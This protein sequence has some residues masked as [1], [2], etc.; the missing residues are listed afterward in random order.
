MKTI[1]KFELEIKN[2]QIIEMPKNALILQTAQIQNGRPVIWAVCD[3]EEKEKSNVIILTLGTG[4][5]INVNIQLRFV[6]IG[7]YQLGS[8]V[9]HVFVKKS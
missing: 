1:W 4:N 5:L 8:F 9:G 6:Y 2:E 3:D 7:T